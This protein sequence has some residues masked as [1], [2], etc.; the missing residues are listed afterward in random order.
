MQSYDQ[1]FKVPGVPKQKVTSKDA[2]GLGKF[3]FGA[4]AN[5]GIEFHV[6]GI[7]KRC[8]SKQESHIST[9]FFNPRQAFPNMSFVTQSLQVD[10]P[11]ISYTDCEISFVMKAK[12]GSLKQQS[13]SLER[14]SFFGASLPTDLRPYV[15]HLSP[16][17]GAIT[18]VEQDDKA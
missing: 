12:A 16:W 11:K 15:I 10:I 2:Q 5:R 14:E 3:S 7:T 18:L 8:C 17:Y 4:R 13:F 9:I 6:F 1:I